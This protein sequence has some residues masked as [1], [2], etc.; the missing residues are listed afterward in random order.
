VALEVVASAEWLGETLDVGDG[1]PGAVG[2]FTSDGTAVERWQTRAAVGPAGEFR[3]GGLGPGPH[4]VRIEVQDDSG[5]AVHQ[6]LREALERVVDAPADGVALELSGAIVEVIVRTRSGPLVRAHVQVGGVAEDESESTGVRGKG[7]D[8]SGRA[9]FLVRAGATY[10]V[11][12]SSKGLVEVSRTV[13]APGVGA[14]HVEEILLEPTPPPPNRALVLR[15]VTEAGAP[16]DVA[17]VEAASSPFSGA[18]GEPREWAGP[19]SNGRFRIDGAPSGRWRLA[20]RPG[21]ISVGSPR[22]WLEVAR[23]VDVAESGDTEV[24][25]ALRLGG[26]LLLSAKAPDGSLLPVQCRVIDASGTSAV[27]YFMIRHQGGTSGHS[28]ALS[29]EGPAQVEPALPPG[30]YTV[31]VSHEG[32]LDRTVEATVRAGETTTLEISMTPK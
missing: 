26:W 20:V 29:S 2:S 15:F 17:A 7:T 13:R 1:E 25:V 31:S 18:D 22:P 24:A 12:A 32:Y 19:T 27:R 14:E 5:V 3:I 11:S 4:R 30:V 8:A 9:R 21:G 23:E 6:D 16:A 10:H 28:G